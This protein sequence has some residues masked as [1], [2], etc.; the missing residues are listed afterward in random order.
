MRG[1]YGRTCDAVI[2]SDACRARGSFAQAS[3]GTRSSNDPIGVCIDAINHR[4]GYED[5][6]ESEGLLH[7]CLYQSEVKQRENGARLH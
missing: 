2:P 6:V 5:I 3:T 4:C 7:L 1:R